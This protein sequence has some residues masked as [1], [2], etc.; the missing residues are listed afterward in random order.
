MILKPPGTAISVDISLFQCLTL[1]R[2]PK[3]DRQGPKPKPRSHRY[4]QSTLTSWIGTSASAAASVGVPTKKVNL[5]SIL[6]QPNT[7]VSTGRKQQLPLSIESGSYQTNTSGLDVSDAT[8]SLRTGIFG[9]NSDASAL[10]Q[11]VAPKHA[12]MAFN[13]EIAF[14][15]TNASPDIISH[16]DPMSTKDYLED[17]SGYWEGLLTDEKPTLVKVA[18]SPHTSLEQ[19]QSMRD[20][21]EHVRNQCKKSLA[22]W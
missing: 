8:G 3:Y 12:T 2:K 7:L 9:K 22:H 13:T 15:E 17:D 6:Q 11:P 1:T 4:R 10:V 16:K 21:L 18:P 19:R 5:L 14:T 20:V